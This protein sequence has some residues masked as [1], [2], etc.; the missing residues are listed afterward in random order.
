[1]IT[2]PLSKGVEASKEIQLQEL[3][4]RCRFL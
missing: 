4:N 1:L 2:V 3:N